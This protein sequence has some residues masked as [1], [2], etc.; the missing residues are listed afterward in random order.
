M[1]GD[2]LALS[3]CRYGLQS[4]AW[5][6]FSGMQMALDKLIARYQSIDNGKWNHSTPNWLTMLS[7][8]PRGLHS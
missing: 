1:T 6:Q 2:E 4:V 5:L 8:A 7:K 3:F